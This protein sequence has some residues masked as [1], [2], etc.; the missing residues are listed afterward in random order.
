MKY[1]MKNN[2]NVEK[3]VN[4]ALQMVGLDE[5]YLEKDPFTLSN[6]EMRKVAIASILAFNPKVIILDEPTVGLDNISKKI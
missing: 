3:H 2:L 4:D 5:S 6:G 1:F